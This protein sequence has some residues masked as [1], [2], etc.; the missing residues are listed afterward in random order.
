M[1]SEIATTNSVITWKQY[2]LMTISN[3]LERLQMFLQWQY[4]LFQIQIK[5]GH[6]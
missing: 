4:I 3:F 1:T 2:S 5:V 6:R